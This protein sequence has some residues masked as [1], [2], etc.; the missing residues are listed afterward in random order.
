[1]EKRNQKRNKSTTRKPR[2]SIKAEG[3]Y[4]NKLL[5]D[6]HAK[7]IDASKLGKRLSSSIWSSF[8]SILVEDNFNMPSITTKTVADGNSTLRICQYFVAC[9]K[10]F[11]VFKYDGHAYGTTGLVKHVKICPKTPVAPPDEDQKSN[12]CECNAEPFGTNVDTTTNETKPR[13]SEPSIKYLT[14][15]IEDLRKDQAEMKQKIN[16]LLNIVSNSTY[17]LHEGDDNKVDQ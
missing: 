11:S 10:C 8:G 9:D 17:I 15:I 4:L 13:R 7:V 6:G 14:R 5:R 3:N 2:R 1:M 12:V 16:D